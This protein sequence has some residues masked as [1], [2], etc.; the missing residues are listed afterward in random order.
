MAIDSTLAVRRAALSALAASARLA[1]LV[2]RESIYP[3]RPPNKPSWPFI[4]YDTIVGVPIRATCLD[5]QQVTFRVHGFAGPRKQG[6]SVVET[7]EDLAARI[8]AAIAAALDC[9]RLTIPGGTASV[10]WL[11]S[12]LIVDGAEADAFHTIQSFQAR[13][14]T[15]HSPA[16][17]G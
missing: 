13:C 10:R 7:A 12:R 4:R 14:I 6:Q 1:E 15:S 5:G 17:G 11:D 8:G 9:T 16:Q 3:Q 2:S